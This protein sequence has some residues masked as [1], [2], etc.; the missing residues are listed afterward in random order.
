MLL[1]HDI[2]VGK[3]FRDAEVL[4][5]GGFGFIGSHLADRLV[6]LGAC[7]TLIDLD[8]SPERP[9]LI[10]IRPGLRPSVRSVRGNLADPIDFVRDLIR[11]T[12]FK[13]VFNCASFASVV[14]RAAAF[15]Y[16]TVQ[17]NTVGLL[18]LLES[19]RTDE[20]RPLSIVHTSTDKVYGDSDG[21]PYDEE[22]SRLQAT[23][24]YDVSKLAADIFARMYHRVYGLSTV[25]LRLCNIFGPHD[26]NTNYRVV[27]KAM[28]SLLAGDRPEP[29]ELYSESI[30]HAREYLYI[31]DCVRVLMELASTPLCWGKVYN[32]KGC[33]YLKTPSM[34]GSVLEAAAEVERRTDPI[35]ASWIDEVGYRVVAQPSPGVVTIPTQRASG[36]RLSSALGFEPRITL[37]EGLSR[38]AAGYH[39]YFAKGRS[40]QPVETGGIPLDN[41][42]VLIA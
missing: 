36:L 20:R 8:T 21:E 34:I 11:A 19:I 22:L 9:S 1:Q 23:G 39:D 38:T 15:P 18:N 42:S 32:L 27:P 16:E 13:A 41:P 37:A 5:T 12:P 3:F 33:A 30:N 17:T 6:E 24:V 28:K 40:R 7:V 2:R 25:V 14:E 26:F 31:D 4:I 10:N 35:R 29:P